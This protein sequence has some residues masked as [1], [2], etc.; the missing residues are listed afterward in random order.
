MKKTLKFQIPKDITRAGQD[1]IAILFPFT[2]VNSS[3]IG[4]PEEMRE[5]EHH[6]LI[7]EIGESLIEP[8]GISRKELIKVLF[9]IGRREIEKKVQTRDLKDEEKIPLSTYNT[10][11]TCPFEPSKI[12]DP[13][14]YQIE[15]EEISK[16]GFC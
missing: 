16:I 8:W 4:Q 11:E 5:T 1:G 14:G 9:E 12:K 6:K 13:D 15:V 3:F 7:V 10:K 2:V